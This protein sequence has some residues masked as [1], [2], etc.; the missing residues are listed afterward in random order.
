MV[1]QT[2]TK[3]AIGTIKVDQAIQNKKWKVSENDTRPLVQACLAYIKQY[4]TAHQ[5]TDQDL[6]WLQDF[7]NIFR[8][9]RSQQ[10][11]A[12]DIQQ[13]I[14]KIKQEIVA[15][16]KQKTIL[17][18]IQEKIAAGELYVKNISWGSW[19]R[20][21]SKSKKNK[22]NATAFKIYCE[23]LNLDW[24]EIAAT[25]N[26]VA[27]PI[28]QTVSDANSA[29]LPTPEIL[30][31]KFYDNLP[32]PRYTKFIGREKNLPTLL[33]MVALNS[34][35]PRISIVGIGGVGKTS[36]VLK[37]AY[38]CQQASQTKSGANYQ[39]DA[40]IFTSFKQ[41][42]ITSQ[43]IIEPTFQR[44]L[45]CQQI[46]HT[47]ART[48]QQKNLIKLEFNN[49]AEELIS[50]L[51]LYK[52]LLII[53]NLE[54][55]E[56][57]NN[58]LWFLNQLPSTVKIVIT[59]RLPTGWGLA[60]PIDALSQQSAFA[61]IQY[62]ADQQNIHLTPAQILEIYEKTCGIP[63]AINL[64]IGQLAN[65]YPLEYVV[66]KL[67]SGCHDV[68]QY[69]FASSI[70]ALR[71]KFSYQLLTTLSLFAKI[72]EQTTVTAIANITD[73][74][75]IIQSFAEL[76]QLSLIQ[77]IDQ[78][79]E[80]L[81]IIRNYILTEEKN[82]PNWAREL[83]ENWVNYYKNFVTE[84]G[85]QDEKEWHDYHQLELE[86]DNL[87]EVM[88][89]SIHNNRYT[90]V[91]Y[92]WQWMKGYSLVRGYQ[93]D[94]LLG[95]SDRLQ[96]T[97]WL[98][99]HATE[100]QDYPTLTEVMFDHAWTLTLIGTK[101]KVNEVVKL[102]AQAWHKRH[103]HHN[104]SFHIDLALHIIYCRLSQSKITSV[105]KWLKISYQILTN[106]EKV[107]EN[108]HRQFIM[109]H[110]YSGRA[111]FLQHNYEKAE[112]LFTEALN[113]AKQINWQR[114]MAI[115]QKWL[116]DVALELKKFREAERQFEDYLAIVTARNDQVGIAYCQQSF[117]F[118]EKAQ[119]N[120]EKCQKWAERAIANFERLGMMQE[121]Q[122]TANYLNMTISPVCV[123]GN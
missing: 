69:C 112:I 46:L 103:K 26:P 11:S 74:E 43:G 61:L 113:L 4:Q 90:D 12:T 18:S 122:S 109:F 58:T 55:A 77:K 96:W 116:G 72:P 47:I 30:I 20:F 32:N 101:E 53:D 123:R 15:Q 87:T 8:I 76:E 51:K 108:H 67:T 89:W 31:P 66:Q 41:Q 49:C 118:L 6:R 36:L 38:Y 99:D 75:Q 117:A 92:I 13:K 27:I 24:Q 82:N 95:W 56:D 52:T 65:H 40:I 121:A 111:E 63:L 102:F 115:C 25:E 70:L 23:I 28:N 44:Q 88:Q 2:L 62:E 9:E 21:A 71:E 80:M 120:I 119:G 98:I 7:Q 33:K 3:S 94:R 97:K 78:K 60:L 17:Q 42:E 104:P 114:G 100:Q 68:V 106:I 79:Y 110:Y 81:S 29:V 105:K 86:W 54:T 5:F 50:L 83:R 10:K 64:S 37:T 93:S 19:E 59:S 57:I 85:G 48:L 73:Q 84:Y 14:A 22:I 1:R 91:K 16:T 39:Y 35:I 34:N 107:T 45:S